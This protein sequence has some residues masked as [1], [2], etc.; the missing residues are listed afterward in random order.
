MMVGY[1]A[2]EGKR[3]EREKGSGWWEK[4]GR[5]G[6]GEKPQVGVGGLGSG[7][8]GGG[9]GGGVKIFDGCGIEDGH[10]LGANERGDTNERVRQGRVG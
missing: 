9:E 1:K 10:A 8:K 2:G 5:W 6:G 4:S 3:A 7:K